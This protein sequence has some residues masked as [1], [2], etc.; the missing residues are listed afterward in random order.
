MRE[1][2]HLRPGPSEA[3][4]RGSWTRPWSMVVFIWAHDCIR[5]GVH[6]GQSNVDHGDCHLR[7]HLA[8][9]GGVHL[10]QILVASAECACATCCGPT[11]GAWCCTTLICDLF[12][13]VLH[14]R[15]HPCCLLQLRACVLGVVEQ[16]ISRRSSSAASPWRRSLFCSICAVFF[17]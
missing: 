9:H 3:T 13:V 14:H 12:C 7:E 2:V 10:W 4:S 15:P 1:D 6:L 16:G 17:S 8:E 5:G 11:C